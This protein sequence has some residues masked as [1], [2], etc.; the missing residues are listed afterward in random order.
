MQTVPTAFHWTQ[1]GEEVLIVGSFS[2]W[3]EFLPMKKEGNGK[4][5]S[6]TTDLPVGIHSY[7][8]VVDGEWRYADEQEQIKDQNGNI[9]NCISIDANGT[10]F[11]SFHFFFTNSN[12]M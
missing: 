2:G 8:F 4:I 5:F 6:Y 3:K 9:N 12:L 7:K 10:C 1:G 11:Y